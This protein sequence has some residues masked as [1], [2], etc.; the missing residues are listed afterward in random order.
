M[1]EERADMRSRQAKTSKR[2]SRRKTKVKST[3]FSVCLP[4][5]KCTMLLE[6]TSFSGDSLPVSPG[7]PSP[8]SNQESQLVDFDLDCD[9]GSLA[10]NLNECTSASKTS[11]LQQDL[12]SE[13]ADDGQ[14]AP[15][16]H[17]SVTVFHDMKGC[18]QPE[19]VTGTKDHEV[20]GEVNNTGNYSSQESSS[21]TW[22]NE[23]LQTQNEEV[24]PAQCH[25][26]DWS[27]NSSSYRYEEGC[28]EWPYNSTTKTNVGTRVEGS[29]E[30]RHNNMSSDA[31]Q[32][33]NQQHLHNQYMPSDNTSAPTGIVGNHHLSD[34]MVTY[35]RA[36]MN[37]QSHSGDQLV[38][39]G[40]ITLQPGVELEAQ[41]RQL[42]SYTEYANGHIQTAPPRFWTQSTVYQN[43]QVVSGYTSMPNHNTVTCT[44]QGWSWMN[45]DQ[46]YPYSGGSSGWV[47]A[48][49]TPF[50]Q[51][52][53]ALY[54]G[55][56]ANLNF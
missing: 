33:Y 29:R 34:E 37:M 47:G 36:R 50:S 27:Y 32:H 40:S 31:I 25:S 16:R 19:D 18:H 15:R 21:K 24:L 38:Q 42:H 54:Y 52:G 7:R 28:T 8:H 43:N 30:G 20:Q 14:Y 45:P 55:A 5:N 23:D 10:A 3:V 49:T 12:C 6:R 22:R 44:G 56:Y 39:S 26:Q 48:R 9:T 41:Q 17:F 35:N 53:Q 2:R 46:Y 11:Q 4:V 51:P 1:S 13:D